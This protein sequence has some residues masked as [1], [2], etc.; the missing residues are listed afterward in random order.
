MKKQ[1]SKDSFCSLIK[2][3]NN[4]FHKFRRNKIKK[5]SVDFSSIPFIA[6]RKIREREREK[7]EK[8]KGKTKAEWISRG[9]PRDSG[10]K[11]FKRG[12]ATLSE[13]GNA[14]FA[15]ARRANGAERR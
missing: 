5:K 1:N 8:N 15:G 2:K 10:D 4:N 6:S 12:R 13:D 3:K 7:K 14:I 9:N 11:A